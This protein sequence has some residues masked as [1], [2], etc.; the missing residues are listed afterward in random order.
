MWKIS[1]LSVVFRFRHSFRLCLSVCLSVAL[2]SV[3]WSYIIAS[4]STQLHWLVDRICS[5]NRLRKSSYCHCLFEH[6][7]SKWNL[8]VVRILL[9][10]SFCRVY[11]QIKQLALVNL[12]QCTLIH[13]YRTFS[14]SHQWKLYSTV[15][16]SLD[17]AFYTRG[18]WTVYAW[19]HRTHYC[20]L[21]SHID[22]SRLFVSPP[23][24]TSTNDRKRKWTDTTTRKW[25]WSYSAMS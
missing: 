9:Q 5:G 14:I 17:V 6:T 8:V 1:F 22:T 24:R 16:H 19:L 13:S 21:I 3:L 10:D 4:L 18:A 20:L 11:T 23:C 15:V 2:E 12:S 25:N 7:T